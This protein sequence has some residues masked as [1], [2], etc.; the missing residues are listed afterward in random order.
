MR[1]RGAGVVALVAVL[2]VTFGHLLDPFDF[3]TFLHAGGDVLHGRIPYD[4]PSSPVFRSGHAF[5]YP[6]YVAWLF[7]P[8]AALPRWSAEAVYAVASV[9]AIVVSC[10]LLG[11]RGF[12]AA[13]LVLVCSTTIV[14]LQMGTVN[15]FLLL[16]LACAWRWRDTRPLLAG[17]ILGA[18]AT[19]KLFLLP[20]L[21]WPVL[22]R[23]YGQAAA[24]A[25]SVAGLMLLSAALGPFSPLQYL[26]M[27]SKLDAREQV[28]SWS[29]SSLLQGLGAGRSWAGA[30]AVLIAAAWL[31]GIWSQRRWLADGQ[32]L[33]AVVL[34]SLLVSPILWSSYLL[35]LVVPLMLVPPDDR[36]LALFAL[37]SWAIVTPDAASPI[38]VVVGAL[39]AA[40]VVAITMRPPI[41][42]GLEVTLARLGA[43]RRRAVVR[44]ALAAGGATAAFALVMWAVPGPA[45]S[46]V[47]AVAAIVVVAVYCLRPAR[48]SPEVKATVLGYP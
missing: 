40:A 20:A 2:G 7:A 37:G 28:Q 43:G 42:R 46:P 22:R 34:C 14:G 3:L 24:A 9:A 45:R 10:R 12:A 17:V 15:A 6:L 30:L 25:G 29:L 33:A 26:E 41:H 27:M 4:S 1:S 23:R 21:L 13:G 35:L 32:M 16:G 36:L 39:V 44:R 5:V 19:A 47:P 31:L 11:R 38:R 8:L 18:T 48:S